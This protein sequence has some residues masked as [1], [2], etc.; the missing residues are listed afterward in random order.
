MCQARV[1]ELRGADEDS[2]KPRRAHALQSQGV[3]PGADEVLKAVRVSA[4]PASRPG[5]VAGSTTALHRPRD[6]TSTCRCGHPAIP[7]TCALSLLLS[8]LCSPLLPLGA[9]SLSIMRRNAALM[10]KLIGQCNVEF[11]GCNV[12]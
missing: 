12:E 10:G 11:T 4:S 8:A 7:P 2:G 9:V 6:P 3:G 5:C 1:E